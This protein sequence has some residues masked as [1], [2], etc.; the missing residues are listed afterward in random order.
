MWVTLLS[1]ASWIRWAKAQSPC[2][3]RTLG[4]AEPRCWKETVTPGDVPALAAA[5]RPG[6]EVRLGGTLE[7]PLTD[8][9]AELLGRLD[10]PK[11]SQQ[12]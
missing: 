2:Q 5:L 6:L 7:A 9:L 11:T 12:G 3:L 8:R 10:D 4:C 1:R